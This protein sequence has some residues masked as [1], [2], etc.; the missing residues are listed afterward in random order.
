MDFIK[1]IEI[2][3]E[4]AVAHV[5]E[6]INSDFY[7]NTVYDGE[8]LQ[9]RYNEDK[10]TCPSQA[11]QTLTIAIQGILNAG[12]RKSLKKHGFGHS[13]EV[14]GYDYIILDEEVEFKLCGS[15]QRSHFATGGRSSALFDKKVDLNWVIKYEFSNNRIS[16]IGVVVVDLGK[17]TRTDWKAAA[18]NTGFSS[19]S[20]AKQDIDAILQTS[21]GIVREAR[22]L[23]QLIPTEI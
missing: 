6:C 20:V 17:C 5:N 12:I 23:S 13:E 11:T 9:D 19:L 16:K 15:T 1:A 7:I 21:H 18:E 14:T 3:S 4:E 10:V 22:K 8:T 2:I